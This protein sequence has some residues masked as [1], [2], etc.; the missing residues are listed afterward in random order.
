MHCFRH[1]CLLLSPSLR[2]IDKEGLCAGM[3]WQSVSYER[4][5]MI[6]NRLPPPFGRRNDVFVFAGCYTPLCVPDFSAGR[7]GVRKLMWW[8][9]CLPKLQRR[10][11]CVTIPDCNSHSHHHEK[12]KGRLDQSLLPSMGL[13]GAERLRLL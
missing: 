4:Q 7:E 9:A 1:H 8:R 11:G 10:W 3:L 6:A 12:A 13:R 2:S 5:S